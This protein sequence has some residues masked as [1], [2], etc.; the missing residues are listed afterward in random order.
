MI[1]DTIVV[2]DV[3]PVVLPRPVITKVGKFPDE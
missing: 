2:D 1:I 3:I